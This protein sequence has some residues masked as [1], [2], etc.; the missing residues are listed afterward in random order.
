MTIIDWIV[1]IIGEFP[2]DLQFIL[3]ITASI[4]LIIS[5]VLII[6]MFFGIAFAIF[7]RN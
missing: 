2:E 3:F 1:G 6:S 7:K 5:T 4:L